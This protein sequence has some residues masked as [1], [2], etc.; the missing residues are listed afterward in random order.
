MRYNLWTF[1]ALIMLPGCKGGAEE[2][3]AAPV[4]NK[5]PA[6]K[7][8]KEKPGRALMLPG[9]ELARLKGGARLELESTATSAVKGYP[10]RKVEQKLRLDL[11]ADGGFHARKDTHEQLGQE[12]IHAGGWL[13]AR[14]RHSKFTRRKPAEG[15]AG[16]VLDRMASHLPGYL[17]LLGPYLK[18]EG[19]GDATH[20]G[21]PAQ[22]VTLSLRPDPSPAARAALARG[23]ARKWRMEAVV[24]K[25]QGTALLDAETRVPLA[26]KLGATLTFKAPR[27]S[28][29]VPASGL[30]AVM[31]DKLQGEMTIALEQKVT[32]VGKVA[33]IKPPPA[34][35]TITDVRRRRL[36]LERQMLTGEVAVP[37]DWSK[38]P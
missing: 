15:E 17:E 19:A 8:G 34:D 12:V 6:V 26:V 22:K 24:T 1:L 28:K 35:Q 4:I 21:R 10:P 25:L 29:Q 18:L 16:R 2:P 31:S 32:R 7:A 20:E 3:L 23:P 13:H 36:E 5:K 37:D 30:P 14:L 27:P 9:R 33:L 38:E 11:D